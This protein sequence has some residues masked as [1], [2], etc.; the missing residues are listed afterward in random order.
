VLG[1]RAAAAPDDGRAGC[2]QPR[3]VFGEGL[4]P[5]RVHH[6][7]LQEPRLAGHCFLFGRIEP[8]QSVSR[9]V[10]LPLSGLDLV[11]VRLY[12]PSDEFVDE[13]RELL[14]RLDIEPKTKRGLLSYLDDYFRRDNK[15]GISN[16]TLLLLLEGEDAVAEG[17]KARSF[18][19]LKPRDTH[20]SLELL[21]FLWSIYI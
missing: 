11:G 13:Y 16:R 20:R 4:G 3:H 10:K 21:Q 6:A 1:R 2:H 15:L 17:F 12:A 18:L 14:A 19:S 8:D 5:Y 9:T 7:P